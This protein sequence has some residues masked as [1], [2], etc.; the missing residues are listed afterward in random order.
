MAELIH[1]LGA[2]AEELGDVDQAEEL[3][4]GHGSISILDG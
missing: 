1:A 2:H 4:A 3:A